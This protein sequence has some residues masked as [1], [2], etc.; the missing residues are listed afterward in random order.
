MFIVCEYAKPYRL[1]KKQFVSGHI[2]IQAAF[3]SLDF[4]EEGGLR[5][6]NHDPVPSPGKL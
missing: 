3:R 1:N 4:W 5:A 6:V 2:E